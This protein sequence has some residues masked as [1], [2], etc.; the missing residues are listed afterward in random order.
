LALNPN[1][2]GAHNARG[3]LL[4]FADIDVAGTEAEFKR[5]VQ[6]APNDPNAIAALA[7]AR[8]ALGHPEGAVEPIRQAI[9]ADPLFANWYSVLEDDLLAL[10]RLDEAEA[11]VR[12]EL[13]LH[14]SNGALHR[15]STIDILRG[16]AAAA[17]AKAEQVP[18]GT[19]RDFALANA[20]Q[21]GSDRAAA[22]ASLKT[23]IDRYAKTDPYLIAGT[24]ALRK[25]PDKVFEWLDRAWAQHDNNVSILYYDPFLLPYKNDPRFAMFCRKIGLPTPTEVAATPKA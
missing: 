8:A 16:N 18:A 19:S 1:L 6:L 4:L 12:R 2:A 15:L 5:D 22:D 14:A 24:C 7:Q 3:V 10:G 13:T 20:R 9:A 25:D 23:V 21:I 17:L 11:A